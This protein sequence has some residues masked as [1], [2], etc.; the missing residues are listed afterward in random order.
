MRL[1]RKKGDEHFHT[2]IHIYLNILEINLEWLMLFL[3]TLHNFPL[4]FFGFRISRICGLGGSL[5]LE[6]SGPGGVAVMLCHWNRHA[7]DGASGWLFKAEDG[8]VVRKSLGWLRNSGLMFFF[9]R[10]LELFWSLDWLGLFEQMTTWLVSMTV[11]CVVYICKSFNWKKP[12]NFWW[13]L[14]RV[15]LEQTKHLTLAGVQTAECQLEMLRRVGVFFFHDQHMVRLPMAFWKIQE[16]S[17][18]S[19]LFFPGLDPCKKSDSFQTFRETCLLKV[20]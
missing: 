20:E 9:F 15:S 18:L 14:G 12:R 4:V 11:M 17:A 2:Y 10:Q 7:I 16:T 6:G 3:S 13:F 8:M 19:N 5:S 1:S